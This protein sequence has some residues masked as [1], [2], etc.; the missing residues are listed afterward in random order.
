MRITVC[1]EH[2][3]KDA[4]GSSEIEGRSLV[5]VA[6]GHNVYLKREVRKS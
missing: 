1:T 5:N 3:F 2:V 4:L 6:L